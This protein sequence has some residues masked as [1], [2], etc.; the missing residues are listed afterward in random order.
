MDNMKKYDHEVHA[1]DHR[2]LDNVLEPLRIEALQVQERFSHATKKY[3]HDRTTQDGSILVERQVF[4]HIMDRLS[5]RKIAKVGSWNVNTMR[6][7][8]KYEV[9]RDAHGITTRV[10]AE[11][12][13]IRVP[14]KA[15]IDFVA[16]YELHVCQR[17]TPVVLEESSSKIPYKRTVTTMKFDEDRGYQKIR[18]VSPFKEWDK[19]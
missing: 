3:R 4:I 19:L 12:F 6:D 8:L 10:D 14:A 11:N 9:V 2:F 13:S 18:Y 1:Q 16:A 17:G 5:Y 7:E 15:V